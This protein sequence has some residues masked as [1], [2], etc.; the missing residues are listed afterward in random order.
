MAHSLFVIFIACFI[1]DLYATA[2]SFLRLFAYGNKD[3][4]TVDIT[5]DFARYR[6]GVSRDISHHST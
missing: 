3:P 2:H 1:A 6:A 4:K 5:P